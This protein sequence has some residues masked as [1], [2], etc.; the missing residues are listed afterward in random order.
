MHPPHLSHC[1]HIV[2][3]TPNRHCDSY[4]RLYSHVKLNPRVREL[5]TG[6]TVRAFTAA[7]TVYSRMQAPG[8]IHVNDSCNWGPPLYA[9]PV[10]PPARRAHVGFACM[11]RSHTQVAPSPAVQTWR[12]TPTLSPSECIQASRPPHLRM[13]HRYEQ[14]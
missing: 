11:A 4:S 5:E 1:R 6:E 14:C 8:H 12:F 9:W 10:S 3:L 2:Y 7:P 13:S